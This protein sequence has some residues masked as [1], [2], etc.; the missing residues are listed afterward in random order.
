MMSL[1]DFCA[2]GKEES[3]PAARKVDDRFVAN[4]PAAATDG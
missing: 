4:C 3:E 1:S 2:F